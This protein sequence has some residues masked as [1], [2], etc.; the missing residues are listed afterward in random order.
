MTPALQKTT[1]GLINIFEQLFKKTQY[2]KLKKDA[3]MNIPE[4]MWIKCSS[5]KTNIYA[6]D[7]E[8]TKQVCLTC[9]YHMPISAWDRIDL[10][11]DRDS[12]LELDEKI[13]TQIEN[14]KNLLMWIK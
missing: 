12:F 1:W 6:N 7:L 8:E 2:A 4:G 9:G 11:I 5:C 10:I 14:N 3:V 13:K